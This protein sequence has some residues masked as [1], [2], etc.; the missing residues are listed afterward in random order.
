MDVGA[1]I[2]NHTLWLAGVCD[3]EVVALE[4]DP[5][6]AA[7]LARTIALNGLEGRVRVIEAAAGAKAGKGTLAKAPAG[8]T[9]MGK[10][11]P[12]RRGPIRVVTID[13]LEL[14]SV[15]LLKVDVEGAELSVLEGAARTIARDHPWIYVEA[16]GPRLYDRLS[17]WMKAAGYKRSAR[18]ARPTPRYCYRY[19]GGTP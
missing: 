10:V 19:V 13:G 18:F 14:P 17:A 2:G 4:P 8:N 11:V 3:L 7:L 15:S 5:E 9:G 12:G 6:N 16:D 1:H